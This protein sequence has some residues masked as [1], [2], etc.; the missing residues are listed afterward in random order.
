MPPDKTMLAVPILLITVGSGWLLTT[1]GVVP[2]V[3]WAW[4]L[5]LAGVGLLVFII[6]GFDKVTFA[7]GPFLIIASV[8]SVLRQTGRM[9][10]DIEVPIF[11]IVAGALILVARLPVVPMP[12]WLPQSSSGGK[13]EG[14]SGD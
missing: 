6:G 5:G 13:Q 8:L 10:P 11:V 14:E 2:G 1:V 4:S 7:V 12:N 9:R 3:D